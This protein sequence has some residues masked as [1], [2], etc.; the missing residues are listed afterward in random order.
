MRLHRGVSEGDL[1]KLVRRVLQSNRSKSTIPVIIS[2]ANANN[3][4]MISIGRVLSRAGAE[5]RALVDTDLALGSVITVFLPEQ[6]FLGEIVSRTVV[7]RRYL[8][9]LCL[10][11]HKDE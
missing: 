10:I 6:V 7:R 8:V 5:V 1:P 2:G 4:P 3:H 11:Q 9:V